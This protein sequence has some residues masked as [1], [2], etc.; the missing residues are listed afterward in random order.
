MKNKIVIKNIKYK[1]K[2]KF[3]FLNYIGVWESSVGVKQKLGKKK[4]HDLSLGFL[5]F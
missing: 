3:P 4:F 1:H 5:K 2:I